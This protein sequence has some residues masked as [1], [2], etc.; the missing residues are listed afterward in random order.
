[1]EL[2]PKGAHGRGLC[3]FRGSEESRGKPEFQ[4][5]LIIMSNQLLMYSKDLAQAFLGQQFSM[6]ESQ[7]S[8]LGVL[9]HNFHGFFSKP[10]CTRDGD[11]RPYTISS[12]SQ[13]FIKRGHLRI[14]NTIPFRNPGYGQKAV[15]VRTRLS[16]PH[17]LGSIPDELIHLTQFVPRAEGS[18]N[19]LSGD[20][21]K[22]RCS[23]SVHG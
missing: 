4:S 12:G 13:C 19:I 17:D 7:V 18:K 20:S 6:I 11:W 1:M 9:S 23:R 22:V 21:I 3:V 8:A 14:I 2:R 10:Y 5:D 15:A 16:D